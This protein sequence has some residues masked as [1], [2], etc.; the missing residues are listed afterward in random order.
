MTRAAI[1][2]DCTCE[3]H[4][5]LDDQPR[6][7]RKA[8]AALVVG[9]VLAT[10]VGLARAATATPGGATDRSKQ[11][12]AQRLVANERL[13]VAR[14]QRRLVRHVLAQ[15]GGRIDLLLDATITGAT[16]RFRGVATLVVA[17]AW[18]GRAVPLLWRCWA[19][20]V[21]GQDWATAI[22]TMC[23]TLAAELPR[24]VEVVLL[25]DRGLSGAPLTRLVAG[26]G[27]HYLLRV[28]RTTRLR[29]ADG[30]V[31]T[32]GALTTPGTAVRLAGVQ[33]YA[34]RTKP[35]PWVSHWDRA[36][37]T[38]AVGVWPPGAREPWLL[39]TDLPPTR[40]RCH[41]YRRRTWEEELFRDLKSLGWGWHASRVRCPERVERLLLALAL[42]TLWVLVT[43]Q[44][45]IKRGQRA[46]LDD[47]SRRTLSRFRLGLN[48]IHR[49]LA[50]DQPI[51]VSFTF[52][53]TT[54]SAPKLS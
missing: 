17:L 39:V 16:P 38:N 46:R 3:V 30:T 51:R 52:W 15:T 24:G 53:R 26:L 35:R 50:T 23:T 2:H 32:I 21:P 36:L 5:L 20:A 25:A 12:R 49:A 9:I 41:E 4:A 14:A 34:P 43:A 45:V 27:W 40:A 8:L 13:D 7:V 19:V 42:A 33:L 31:T 48:A 10:H 29:L 47:H 28:T 54:H 44:R 11:R 18:Q 1:L 37:I 6:P 22:R